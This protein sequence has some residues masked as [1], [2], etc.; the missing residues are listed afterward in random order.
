MNEPWISGT[1]WRRG[2]FFMQNN[3]QVGT[4]LMKDGRRMIKLI[5]LDSEPYTGGWNLVTPLSGFDF[6]QKVRASGSTFFFMAAEVKATFLGSL[7]VNQ[8]RKAVKKILGKVEQ[9]HFNS[10]EVTGIAS[11]HFLGV[12]YTVVTAHSRHAQQGCYLDGIAQRQASSI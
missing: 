11:K 6:D 12:P 3:I 9:L 10:L 5:G 1:G 7:G 8:I 2:K 4:I